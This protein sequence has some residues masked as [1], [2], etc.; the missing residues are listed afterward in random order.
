MLTEIALAATGISF[1]AYG[2][3][4]LFKPDVIARLIGYEFKN[5]NARV[6]FIAMY[7]G[8]EVAVGVM[9]LAGLVFPDLRYGGL[10]LS[11]LVVGGLA[12]TRLVALLVSGQAANRYTKLALIFELILVAL[13]LA[14]LLQQ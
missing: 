5:A 8:L 13:T 14:A 3:F 2:L 12:L 9:C 11:L 1:A 6:E 4:I 10:W 7:G